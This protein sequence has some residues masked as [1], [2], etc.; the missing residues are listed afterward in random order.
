MHSDCSFDQ[1]VIKDG[2]MEGYASV[3]AMLPSRGVG[4]V[5]LGSYP[6]A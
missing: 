2:A 3:V 1:L 5:A 6:W 4:V